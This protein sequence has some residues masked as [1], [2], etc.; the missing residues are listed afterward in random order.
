MGG[1]ANVKIH[2]ALPTPLSMI[3]RILAFLLIST[4]LVSCG[5]SGYS[6]TGTSKTAYSGVYTGDVRGTDCAGN[7]CTV[8]YS[9][10]ERFSVAPSG[11]LDWLA[12]TG[13]LNDG[14]L[15]RATRVSFTADTVYERVSGSCKNSSGESCSISGVTDGFLLGQNLSLKIDYELSC[16]SGTSTVRVNYAGNRAIDDCPTGYAHCPMVDWLTAAIG[17]NT[18][19][20]WLS[21]AHTG[22]WPVPVKVQIGSELIICLVQGRGWT[23]SGDADEP[24]DA[25]A[26]R[27]KV[28]TRGVD[29]TTATTHR[30]GA[31]VILIENL[32]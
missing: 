24:P 2:R 31:K 30:A 4:L 6:S 17:P 12:G 3:N 7:G 21:G 26:D 29:G 22:M 23:H 1:L 15:D 13:S 19:I 9:S 25:D 20:I 5:G 10:P 8:L 28:C 16:A 14:C 27:L 18:S 11:T 32:R